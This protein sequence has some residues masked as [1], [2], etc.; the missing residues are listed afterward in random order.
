MDH[1]Q[2][3]VPVIGR[4]CSDPIHDLSRTIGGAII[5]CNHFIVVVIEFKQAG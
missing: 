1:S 4:P 2:A 3:T 5:H